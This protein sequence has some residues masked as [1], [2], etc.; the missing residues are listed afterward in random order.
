MLRAPFYSFEVWGPNGQLQPSEFGGR[1]P[2]C[3]L[4]LPPQSLTTERTFRAD[5]GVD[6]AGQPTVV[7]APLG[8]GRWMLRGTHGVGPQGLNGKS[9]ITRPDMVNPVTPGLDARQN[10]VALFEAYA[11]TNQAL[12][13]KGQRM[14]RLVFAVR[15]GGSSEWQNEEWWI[16]PIG[17]PSDDRTAQRPLDWAFSL[18][19]WA[20]ARVAGTMRI[21]KFP[22]IAPP[23]TAQAAATLDKHTKELSTFEK[24][25]KRAGAA[26]DLIM[27]VREVAN[28]VKDLRKAIVEGVRQV[29]TMVRSLVSSIVSLV[30]DL[31]PST[32]FDE[33]MGDL[34][35]EL[36]GLRC[37]LGWINAGSTNL[38]FT[39]Q[40]VTPDEIPVLPGRDLRAIAATILGDADRWAEIADANGLVFPWLGQ[41]GDTYAGAIPGKVAGRGDLL[42][43][44]QS[45]AV[46][47]QDPIGRD[48]PEGGRPGA[49]IGGLDNLVAALSR[50]LRTPKGFLP[51]HPEYGSL[52]QNM[53]GETLDVSLLLSI[54]AEASRV[55]LGDPRVLSVSSVTVETDGMESISVRASITTCAGPGVVAVTVPK[56]Q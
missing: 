3:V 7:E 17:M 18:S 40:T 56:T 19:F 43:V 1:K 5:L 51:H 16:L 2:W 27:K 30:N 46:A 31:N 50:R 26:R 44:Q 8:P 24:L 55:L 47:I 45:S 52:L 49:L 23:T 39:S 41:D 21:T 34:R 53:A 14:N 15:S 4:R 38:A 10:L 12:L 11:E 48:L 22:P 42:T 33:I 25:L 20:L 13:A 54:R 28:K 36:N 29:T 37:D 9:L 6:L 32:L 35:S